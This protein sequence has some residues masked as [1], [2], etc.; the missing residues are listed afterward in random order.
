M[1]SDQDRPLK[2]RGRRD[3][4]AV[5]VRL[6][7]RDLTAQQIHTSPARRARETAELIN[8]E[9]GD[10]ATIH[11]APELYHYGYHE[12]MMVIQSVVEPCPVLMIVGHNPTLE[13]LVENL[14]GVDITIPTA[15]T[16]SIRFPIASW[17][18][19]RA[20]HKVE[21][22]DVIRPRELV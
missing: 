8:E 11:A 4:K 9:W 16:V 19:C 1:L 6:R 20:G 7:E 15:G 17:T 5:A 10:S 12:M 22:M 14:A 21:V 3:S 13:L 18:Q 2:K